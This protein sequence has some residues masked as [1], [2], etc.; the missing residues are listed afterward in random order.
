MN[1]SLG[2]GIISNGS[3]I[4]YAVD[5]ETGTVRN[6]IVF[7]KDSNVDLPTTYKMCCWNILDKPTPRYVK[8]LCIRIGLEYASTL[9]DAKCR[10]YS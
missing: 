5:T 10:R 1:K 9:K 8:K 3:I 2:Y 4:Q 7:Q 6:R